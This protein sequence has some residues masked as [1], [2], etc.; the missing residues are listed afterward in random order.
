LKTIG[1]ALDSL[2][3]RRNKA[4]YDLNPLRE[5]ATPVA[6]EQAILDATAALA[7]LDAIEADPTRRASAI[8][9]F[10]P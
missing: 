4:S 1:F 3:Q 2:V 7:L 8:A 9:S 5:F 6:A 10:P